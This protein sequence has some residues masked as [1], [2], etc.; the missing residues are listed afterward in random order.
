MRLTVVACVTWAGLAACAPAP[1][2][3]LTA[4]GRTA[5]IP[6]ELENNHIIVRARI[7][8]GDPVA[9]ILDSGASA[10]LLDLALVQRLGLSLGETI[11]SEGLGAADA[12]RVV[13]D[14]DMSLPGVAVKNLT[15]VSANLR[16]L[17]EREGVTL[18]RA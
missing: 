14:I 12:M 4:A 1:S 9:L 15:A 3:Q 8:G 18:G 2:F 16:D 7:H 6:F 13:S 17:S 5:T 11:S 10:T